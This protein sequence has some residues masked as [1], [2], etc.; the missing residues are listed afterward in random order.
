MKGG[1]PLY[2]LIEKTIRE[3]ATNF[4]QDKDFV[5]LSEARSEQVAEQLA[6]LEQ[7][8]QTL[9]NRLEN[10]QQQNVSSKRI[11]D[12]SKWRYQRLRVSCKGF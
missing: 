6:E 7:K 9:L 5:K 11:A 4:L 2:E 1:A 8:K 12:R 3:T 10:L